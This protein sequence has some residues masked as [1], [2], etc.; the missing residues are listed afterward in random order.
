MTVT[1][2]LHTQVAFLSGI[3][4]EQAHALAVEVQQQAY[5]AGQNVILRGTTV[6]GL[7]VIASGKVG[8][9]AKPEKKKVLEQVAELG[10]GEVFGETS[11]MEMCTAGATV[12]AV[13]D[14][15]LVFLIPQEA[16]RVV[17]EQ[18]PELAARATAL[19]D[20]R[21]KKTREA[22]T[23]FERSGDAVPA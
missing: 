4:G 21:K 22:L 15:T 8:V 7:Y 13:E 6:D 1:E 23:R 20:S 10:A 5:A 14:E 12:K 11:I 9:W 16:F 18:N 2:F 17:L 19:I 3:T